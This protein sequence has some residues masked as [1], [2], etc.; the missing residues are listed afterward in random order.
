LKNKGG[1]EGEVEKFWVKEAK[2]NKGRGE[3]KKKKKEPKRKG[4]R[5]TKQRGRDC[6]LNQK[7]REQ[8]QKKRERKPGE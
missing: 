5:T 3:K 8:K 4:G 6:F 2:T 7:E 1:N